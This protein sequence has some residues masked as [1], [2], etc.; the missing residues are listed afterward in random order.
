MN[1]KNYLWLDQ[2]GNKF[3]AS[4]I[5]KLRKQIANGSSRVSKMYQDKADGSSVRTGVVIGQHWLTAYAPVEFEN[6]HLSVTQYTSNMKFKIPVIW[7]VAGVME[8]EA[9]SLD[10]A[11]AQTERNTLP[12]NGEYIDDSFEI[13]YEGIHYHNRHIQNALESC[14]KAWHSWRARAY[15][16]RWRD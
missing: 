2:Y 4:S 9:D 16:P 3:F 11:I 12:D 1:N 15:L 10:A 8:I 6:W 5:R 14:E 7:Q 13:D